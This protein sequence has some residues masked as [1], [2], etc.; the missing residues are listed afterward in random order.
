VGKSGKVQGW[1]K[2]PET[3]KKNP[4]HLQANPS[5]VEVF[6]AREKSKQDWLEER[7]IDDVDE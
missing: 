2:R 1:E 4:R 5:V 6:L 3:L 7:E